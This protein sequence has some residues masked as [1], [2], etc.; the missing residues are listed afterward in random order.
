MS[1]AIVY[2]L[3]DPC[4]AC[5]GEVRKRPQPTAAQR[6]AAAN[7]QDANKWV[8]L[9]PHYDTAPLEVVEELGEL[10]TCVDCGYP[11]REKPAPAPAAVAPVEV[12]HG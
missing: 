7:T 9:P 8:P 2:K 5:G 12:T 11:H 4:P 10:H 6:K 3:G 1:G